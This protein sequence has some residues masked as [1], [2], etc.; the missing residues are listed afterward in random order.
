MNLFSV[1]NGNQSC[2]SGIN[3]FCQDDGNFNVFG[4]IEGTGT[5][6]KCANLLCSDIG[7]IPTNYVQLVNSDDIEQYRSV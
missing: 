2:F 1:S 7:M 5:Q 6:L 4:I 3:Y